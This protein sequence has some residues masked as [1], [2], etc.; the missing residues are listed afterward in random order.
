MHQLLMYYSALNPL[1][2]LGFE[3]ELP[4]ILLVTPCAIPDESSA[5]LAD[6]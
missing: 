6:K 5:R 3:F 4:S 1:S 2:E